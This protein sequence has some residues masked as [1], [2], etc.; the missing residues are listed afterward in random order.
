VT[1]DEAIALLIA[2]EVAQ[3]ERNERESML[4]DWWSIDADDPEYA[5]L[6]APLRAALDQ[7]DVPSEPQSALYDPL[8]RVALRH[9]FAGVLNSYLVRRIEALGCSG[10]VEGA[11]EELAAC[12]CCEFRSIGARGDYAIC[13]VCFWED[14]GTDEFDR[15]SVPNRMTLREARENFASIGAVKESMRAHVLPD[16]QE[17]YPRNERTAPP[18]DVQ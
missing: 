17:R 13:L 15:R 12:P 4:E 18:R 9:T 2:N 6:P 3:L 8:L 1:R 16:G 10:P 14:D 5:A 11:A 7:Q